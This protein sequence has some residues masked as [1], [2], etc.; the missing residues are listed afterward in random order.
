MLILRP[1]ALADL[2]R[3]LEL[4]KSA[5]YGMTSLP[6]DE[7]V[8]AGRV[9]ASLR[10]FAA[11]PDGP[12]GETYLFAL[13][14]GPGGLVQGICGIVSKVGGFEPFWSYH[15]E[16]V[17]H[18]CSRLGI[19]KEIEV[20][21]LSAE[22]RGPSEIGS[23]FL[24]PGF[25]RRGAGRLLSLSRFLFMADQGDLFEDEILAEMRGVCDV[26]GRSPFWEAVGR[27][28]FGM[29]FPDADY[30]SMRDKRFIAELMPRHPLYVPLLPSAAQA[31]IGQVH[32][33]TR[34]ALALLLGEGFQPNGH[35]DIFEAG[36]AVSCQR[37]H[38]GAIARSQLVALAAISDAVPDGDELLVSNRQ[39]DDY[40]C[41]LLPVAV[42][43]QGL[44]L[45]REA[46]VA[47]GV[48][49]GDRLRIAAPRTAVPPLEAE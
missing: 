35:V 48:A 15:R 16:P 45:H 40:R 3:L 23:L 11:R 25:R 18:E 29:D 7:K 41:S 33:M 47:L 13:E 49:V 38:I 9:R 19:R 14:D 42:V 12:G 39:F 44:V 30:L 24:H 28:F 2:P 37:Q 22:H 27:H 8:L 4:A 32:E 5:S 26:Q 10:S 46:A 1:I 36:P 31:V 20:L 21:Q 43:P 17:L 34:P 6:P